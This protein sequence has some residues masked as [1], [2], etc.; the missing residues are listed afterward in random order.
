MDKKYKYTESLERNPGSGK[1]NKDWWKIQKIDNPD[2]TQKELGQLYN[3][4]SQSAVYK[5]M[6]KI[7]CTYKKRV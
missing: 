5:V 2:A 7:G 6:K 4:K 1:K 3:G